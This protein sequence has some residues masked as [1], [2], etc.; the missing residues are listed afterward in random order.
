[1]L[2]GVDDEAGLILAVGSVGTRLSSLALV[3]SMR[4][5]QVLMYVMVLALVVVVA[6]G[7]WEEFQPAKEFIR[8]VLE[9]PFYATPIIGMVCLFFAI[10]IISGLFKS[11][12]GREL[13]VG[14]YFCDIK[15]ASA[16]DSSNDA[17]VVTLPPGHRTGLRHKLYEHEDTINV[18]VKFI[19]DHLA[20]ASE[21]RPSELIEQD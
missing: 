19:G 10:P 6:A 9:N 3:L 4:L 5:A 21:Q 13:I 15:S 7:I 2:R 18:I 1:V 16:P 8:S 20:H 17:T 11:V 14:G 12:Y